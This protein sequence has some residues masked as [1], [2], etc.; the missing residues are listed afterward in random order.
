V[1]IIISHPRKRPKKHI[2]F[3]KMLFEHVKFCSDRHITAA[4]I[5]GA[6]KQ[7]CVEHYGREDTG[8]PLLEQKILPGVSYHTDITIVCLKK[9]LRV[10]HG[11][12]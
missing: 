7:R 8:Q 1:R 6:V 3:L 4:A 12:L 9:S 2:I 10:K 5:N 11:V